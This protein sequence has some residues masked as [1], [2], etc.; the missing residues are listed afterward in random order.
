[1]VSQPPGADFVPVGLRDDARPAWRA[2]VAALVDLDKLGVRTPCDE[3]STSFLGDDLDVRLQ[4]A[5]RCGLC[6]IRLQ[7]GT[8]ADANRERVGVWGGRDRTWGAVAQL[9]RRERA[10]RL[11]RGGPDTATGE[12]EHAFS[13]AQRPRS[14]GA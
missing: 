10:E 13:H 12:D 5:K 14:V 4:A 11:R 7:C 8:F 3:N 9:E 2:L 6:P 1:M